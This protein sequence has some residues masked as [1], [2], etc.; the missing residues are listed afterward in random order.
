MV[1]DPQFASR[2]GGHTQGRSPSISVVP[3]DSFVPPF[4]TFV[5]LPSLSSQEAPAKICAKVTAT[6]GPASLST[7]IGMAPHGV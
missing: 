2:K 7:R 1:S 6:R 5:V 3:S 4:H